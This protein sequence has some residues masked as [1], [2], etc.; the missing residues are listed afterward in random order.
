MS[1]PMYNTVASPRREAGLAESTSSGLPATALDDGAAQRFAALVRLLCA[2]ASP[3]EH[4]CLHRVQALLEDPDWSCG[5][6]ARTGLQRLVFAALHDEPAECV[7]DIR[8]P[9]LSRE[10]E[11]YACFTRARQHEARVRRQSVGHFH[12]D[13]HDWESAQQNALRDHVRQVRDATYVPSP[14]DC[15]RVH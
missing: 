8:W 13:R 6:D 4:A 5:A 11:A 14:V 7:R 3:V 12:F 2:D 10:T 9:V 15:F 1:L